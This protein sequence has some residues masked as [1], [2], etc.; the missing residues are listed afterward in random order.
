M[1]ITD[2]GGIEYLIG[3]PNKEVKISFNEFI[4]NSF[5]D[6][7]KVNVYFYFNIFDGRLI[8]D[9][10]ERFRLDVV[11]LFFSIPYNNYV[12]NEIY[13][14]VGFYATVLYAYLQSLW[15]YVIG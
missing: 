11:S 7:H 10:M 8:L 3:F 9:D 15:V 13:S 6:C 4:I 12:N 14:S 5:I 1:F 2:Q